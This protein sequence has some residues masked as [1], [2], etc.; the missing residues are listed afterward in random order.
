MSK[1]IFTV[2]TV[3]SITVFASQRDELIKVFIVGIENKPSELDDLFGY[4]VTLVNHYLFWETGKRSESLNVEQL[5]AYFQF[6]EQK[7][8]Q[9]NCKNPFNPGYTGEI[10]DVVPLET[11]RDIEFYLNHPSL[12]Y[13]KQKYSANRKVDLAVTKLCQFSK[14]AFLSLPFDPAGLN[15]LNRN[16]TAI[17]GRTEN[18]CQGISYQI[19]KDV[20]KRESSFSETIKDTQL[21]NE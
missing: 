14:L 8:I 12:L 10:R 21:C 9:E 15:G 2:L 4:D 1:F 5:I 7:F 16:F 3:F 18:F 6:Y 20:L 19:I 11:I 13:P 17:A